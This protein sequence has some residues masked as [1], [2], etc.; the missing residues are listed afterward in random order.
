MDE[1]VR[2]DEEIAASRIGPPEV[3]NASIYLAEYD[4]AWPGLFER[5]A[6]RIRAALGDRALLIEHVGSTS[7]SGLL[8]NSLL[9][10][11]AQAFNTSARIPITLEC[12]NA[13]GAVKATKFD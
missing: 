11:N 1:T 4:H 13:D 10:G 9:A 2:S 3:L 7:V 5:E 12:G 6:D 8:G